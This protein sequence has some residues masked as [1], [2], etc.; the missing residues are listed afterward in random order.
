MTTIKSILEDVLLYEPCKDISC[1]GHCHK[2][3]IDQSL[4]QIEQLISDE[5]IGEDQEKDI[6]RRIDGELDCLTCGNYIL[7]GVCHCVEIN[8]DKATQR[9]NLKKVIR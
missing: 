8:E 5:V 2:Y 6:T 1:K 3:K 9:A 4:Q 7:G